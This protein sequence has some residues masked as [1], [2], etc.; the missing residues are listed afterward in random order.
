MTK[1][2][3][4]ASWDACSWRPPASPR[5]LRPADPVAPSGRA[6][7]RREV[8]PRTSNGRSSSCVGDR[9]ESVGTG[10]PGRRP[11]HRPRQPGAPARPDRRPHAHPSPGRPDGRRVRR[12]DPQGVPRAPGRPRRA[13]AEDRPRARL[14][15]D[16][17]PRDRRRRLRR[18]RAARRRQRG[19]G[20]GAPP[21]GRRAGALDDRLLP[22]P[23][24]PAGLEVP[25]AASWSAT[26]PTAAARPSASSSR[27]APTGSRSTRIPEACG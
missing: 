22:D 16:A 18:R 14:H 3:T 5:S 15:D 19:R 21:E 10:R 1:R 8:R 26:A 12:A 6:P 24:L 25:V 27:T 13:G 4:L 9:I 23:A 11:R 20:S 7:P 2:L 17:G